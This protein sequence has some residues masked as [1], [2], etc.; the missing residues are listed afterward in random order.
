[1]TDSLRRTRRLQ[2]WFLVLLAISTALLGWWLVDQVRYTGE[3]RAQQQAAYEADTAA[4]RAL[5]RAGRSWRDVHEI[6]PA[7]TITADSATIAVSPVVVDAL[8]RQR[9]HRLNRYAWEGSFFLLVLIS[10]MII[11]VRAIREEAELRRG[12]EQFLAGMSHE[13]KSPLASLRLSV[14]T[15]A[16]RD[17]PAAQRGELV[18]RMLVE[19]GRL[20]GTIANV[21]DTS[22]LAA[23]GRRTPEPIGLASEVEHVV[24]ELGDFAGEC[25]VAIDA[26]VPGDLTV[27]GE[28]DGTRIVLRNLLH[29]AIKASPPGRTVRVRAA[30]GNGKVRLEVRDEGSGF[31]AAESTRLF[32][33]F[34][35]IDRED[36]GGTRGTG[37]GL[38]LV[39][40]HVELDLGTVSAESEGPGQG[41]TFTVLWPSAGD[42]AS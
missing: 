37:L 11:V 39:R 26:S 15:L 19:L 30:G 28:R 29:N 42:S 6:F 12:Q 35:R 13:L 27:M 20:Q 5:L 9:F 33:K 18:R 25:G 24:E 7:L 4:A 40:R 14:E 17:P 2:R 16:M 1:V 10:A 22:R 38:F 31:S 23:A 21:L 36:R 8:H 32:E 3:V 41:A 34:Y